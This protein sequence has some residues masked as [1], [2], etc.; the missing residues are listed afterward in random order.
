MKRRAGVLIVS[1]ALLLTPTQA[2]FGAGSAA[3]AGCGP[4]LSLLLWPKGY[5]AYP[6]PSFEVFRGLSGPYGVSNILA[7]AAATKDGTLGY[8]ATMIGS[9]CVDIGSGGKAAT[10]ATLAA[11]A[12]TPLRLA[13][14]FPKP[15]IVK[16]DRLPKLGKRLRVVLPTGAVVADATVNVNGSSVR[17]SSA[18][19]ARKGA[20]IEPTS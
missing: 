19:C 12:A 16:I 8:P 6:L 2:A 7:Y 3:Q 13:C 9:D 4:K 20:L 15:P 14:T 17:Y 10:S 1:G 18:Y 5:E 11:K